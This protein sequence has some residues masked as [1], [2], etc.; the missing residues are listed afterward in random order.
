MTN[1]L[2]DALAHVFNFDVEK[3]AAT[4]RKIHFP[5]SKLEGIVAIF[6]GIRGICG[7]WDNTVSD[8]YDQTPIAN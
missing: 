4:R 5:V 1:N 3:G 6:I 2:I 7:M 8:Q